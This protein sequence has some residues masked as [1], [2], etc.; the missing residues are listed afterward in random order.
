MP[1]RS[2]L[3]LLILLGGFAWYGLLSLIRGKLPQTAMEGGFTRQHALLWGLAGLL[4]A[5]VAAAAFAVKLWT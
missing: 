2:A 4:A 1:K 3:P 5:M